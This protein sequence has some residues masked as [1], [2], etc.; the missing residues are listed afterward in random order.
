[1]ICRITR[2]KIDTPALL[3]AVKHPEAGAVLAFEGIVRNHSLG[4]RVL[5]LVYDAY[6]EMAEKKLRQ[7]G[8]E[9]AAKW[10]IT[11]VAMVH[12][13]G[14]LEISEASLVIALASAHRADGFA[15]CRY[16]LERI[17]AI[18]PIW[19]KEVWD[20]GEEWIEGKDFAPFDQE[21]ALER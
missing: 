3:A 10:G 21:A 2:E 13:I 15:A 8:E 7:I 17:K 12:R 16:A 19:K 9:V 14:R 4:R 11:Q 6:P 1:M 5:Y 18:L 20:G